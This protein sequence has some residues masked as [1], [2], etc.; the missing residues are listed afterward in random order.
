MNRSGQSIQ[1]F[2]GT[3]AGFDK[4]L[5]TSTVTVNTD[6]G[7]ASAAL[8]TVFD[9]GGGPNGV[10]YYS[11]SSADPRRFDGLITSGTSASFSLDY[12]GQ[13]FDAWT[14]SSPWGGGVSVISN[15]PPDENRVNTGGYLFY[16]NI[17]MVD[18]ETATLTL[19]PVPV[20]EP[21]TLALLAAALAVVPWIWSG[22]LRAANK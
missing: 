2:G 13:P 6:H 12:Q 21:A 17:V 16:S 3:T 4:G 18:L 8:P 10:I 15:M 7:P 14:G 11:G 9:T 5:V 22:R 20:P 19:V 1:I